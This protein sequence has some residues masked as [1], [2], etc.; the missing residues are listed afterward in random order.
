MY[1]LY[2]PDSN[3][4]SREHFKKV[5]ELDPEG[6]AGKDAKKVLESNTAPQYGQRA[7][8][9][10]GG[11]RGGMSILTI[12]G[13]SLLTVVLFSGPIASLFKITSPLVGMLAGT[14]VFIGLY[15]AWGRKR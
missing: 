5:V 6:G 10:A 13:I 15:S 1:A 12:L 4:Q 8:V 14:F 9:G 7:G 2:I 3:E 11:Q